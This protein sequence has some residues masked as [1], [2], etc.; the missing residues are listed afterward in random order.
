MCGARTFQRIPEDCEPERFLGSGLV[1]LL[2]LDRLTSAV[3][4]SVR[5]PSASH[6]EVDRWDT[7]QP[8]AAPAQPE[9]ASADQRERRKLFGMSGEPNLRQLEPARLLAVAR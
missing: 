8:A 3:I 1:Q 2:P 9:A 5:L 7:P 6:R 4:Y